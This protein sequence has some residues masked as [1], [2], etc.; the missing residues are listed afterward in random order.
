RGSSEPLVPQTSSPS[1]ISPSAPLTQAKA[2]G[3]YLIPHVGGQVA[4]TFQSIPG[5]ELAANYNVP[6]ATAA[7]S[8]G[9]PLSGAAANQTV[10]IL[11]PGTS[12]Q[13]QERLNQLDLRIGKVLRFGGT[14]TNVNLDV[15]NLFNKDTVLTQNN[16][17]PVGATSTT[18]KIPT[19]ILQSRL[20]KISAP[21]D[22]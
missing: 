1:R 20:V 22:F 18:W 8:L 5:G 2:V 9:R 14:R 16:A 3:S 10:N 7:L 19:G 15:F 13:Y 4:G 6:T 17:F 12:T 11:T 21:F